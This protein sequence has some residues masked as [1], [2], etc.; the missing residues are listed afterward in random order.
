MG[1]PRML[2]LDEPSEGL[3]PLIVAAL[4]VQINRLRASELSGILIDRSLDFV[5][6]LS[7]RAYVLEKGEMKF[8][9][10]AE[11]LRGNDTLLRHYL[12]V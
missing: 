10:A 7:S 4:K 11:E 6:S 8:S 9:G 3:A 5:L 1:N 12:T 2:L